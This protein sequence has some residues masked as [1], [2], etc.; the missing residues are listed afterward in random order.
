MKVLILACTLLCGLA[1]CNN[2]QTVTVTTPDSAG[3]VPGTAGSTPVQAAPKSGGI[4]LFNATRQAFSEAGKTDSMVIVLSSKDSVINGHV[5]FEIFN[6]AGNSIY[7]DTFPANYLVGYSDEQLDRSTMASRIEDR[8]KHFFDAKNF[9]RPAIATNEKHDAD[10]A[11]V[12][13]TA[14]QAIKDD[15]T[16]VGFGY[17]LGSEDN[18]KIAYSKLLKKVVIY[19]NCC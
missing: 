2:T 17:L 9:Y 19:F 12:E 14:W 11:I 18:K 10:Y 15:A 5:R 3:T 7:L 8:I 1:A 4:Q 16:S 13:K 6:A